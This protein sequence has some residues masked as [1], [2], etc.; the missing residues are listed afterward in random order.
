M[1][2]W[3]AKQLKTLNL[4]KDIIAGSSV[5]QLE[6]QLTI[7]QADIKPKIREVFKGREQIAFSVIKVLVN[8]FISSFGFATKLTNDQVEIITVDAF[9]KF[10]Y[11][12]LEDVI[13][14]LKMA[15]SGEFGTTKRGVDS[16]LIFGEWFPMYQERKSIARE[17]LRE[18]EKSQLNTSTTSYAD[19]AVTYQKAIK[20]KQIEKEMQ[21]LLAWID[22]ITKDFDRQMLED[23]ITDWESD[24]KKKHFSKY[25]KQKRR[26]IK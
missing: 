8:R 21:T 16:N 9:E 26:T 6:L 13:L 14:F 5:A 1:K 7:S 12:S 25:L 11:D 20:K 17:Q 23:L 18:K 19:V 24:E 4:A 22:K 15:R 2:L 10:A 3:E